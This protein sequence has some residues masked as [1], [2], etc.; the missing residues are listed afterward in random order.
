M[1][2]DGWLELVGFVPGLRTD[3]SA[4]AGRAWQ[5]SVVGQDGAWI[6]DV[7]LAARLSTDLELR[8]RGWVE[9]YLWTPAS[10]DTLVMVEGLE[11]AL[12]GAAAPEWAG[13]AVVR[14]EALPGGNVIRT[15]YAWGLAP[16]V[17]WLRGGYAFSWQDS[18]ETRWSPV[19]VTGGQGGPGRGG[20]PPMAASDPLPGRYTPYFTPEQ[21]Y[22]HSLLTELRG[23]VGFGTAR[24]N[25]SY[26]IWATEQ[27][28]SLE[29]GSGASSAFQ[30]TFAERSFNPWSVTGA[31]DVP[32]GCCTALQAEVERA[33]TAFY[34]VTRV[35][36]GLVY[37]FL[38]Q[39]TT[40]GR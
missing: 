9:R 31:V 36:L 19:E 32:Q 22:I 1:A 26:G 7:S 24:L 10:A 8:G 21:T 12:D 17:P 2:A 6:G 11:L 14:R 30:T 3:V 23:K 39:P 18:D 13:E 37:R 25:V 4:K 16:I 33:H 27:V 40:D 34:Q 38:R 29:V 15:A 28:P 20:G 35:S 5:S